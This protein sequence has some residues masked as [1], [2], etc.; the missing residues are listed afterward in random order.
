MRA[1]IIVIALGGCAF[2]QPARPEFEV[3]VVKPSQPG[4]RGGGIRAMPG[5]QTYNATNVPVKLMIKLMYHL[6]D[7]QISG[8]PSWLD[9]ELYD[10]HAKA[11]PA[12]N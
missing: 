7:R 10:V 2:G 6:N 8:G 3:A 4:G 12:E 1:V 11:K 9:T 5:G